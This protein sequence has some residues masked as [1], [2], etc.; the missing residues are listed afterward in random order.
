M[1]IVRFNVIN[2]RSEFSAYRL[3]YV[4]AT[5]CVRMIMEEFRIFKKTCF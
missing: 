1:D 3:G 4:F 5:L 2:V